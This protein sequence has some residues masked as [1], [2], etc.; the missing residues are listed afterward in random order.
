MLIRLFFLTSLVPGS[1]IRLSRKASIC[2][3]CRPGC[4]RFSLANCFSSSFFSAS[5]CS[6]L[7]V[8]R[9]TD[10]LFSRAIQRFSMASSVSLIAAFI[11]LME[12]YSPSAWQTA[13]TCSAMI[14]IRFG[15]SNSAHT[16]ATCDSI[17]SLEIIFLS[18]YLFYTIATVVVIFLT[19][20]TGTTISCHRFATM[21]AE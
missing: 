16:S 4:L 14:R 15:V 17:R 1:S 13:I 20:L 2:V 3:S 6:S 10:C 11:F 21:T 9:S 7:F 19:Q 5:R 18:H 8:M 12:R